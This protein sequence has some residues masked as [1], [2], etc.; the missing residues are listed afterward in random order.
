MDINKRYRIII[1]ICSIL[2]LGGAFVYYFFLNNPT[3]KGTVFLR[4]PSNYLF[5]IFC[6]GCG[7]QRAIHQLLHFNLVEAIR[8]NALLVITFPFLIYIT[9]I[10]LY[11]FVFEKH[12]R[13]KLF[14]N[15]KFV[16]TLFIVIILYGVIRNI[17]VYPFTLLAP[18]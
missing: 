12:V 1:K 2:I 10:W 14:Y 8:Y 6:P 13:I 17:S 4:C 16:W 7:S 9:L 15:N 5:G 3:D 11:N 18:N